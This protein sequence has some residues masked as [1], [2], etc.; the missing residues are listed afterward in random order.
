MATATAVVPVVTA[1]SLVPTATGAA[2]TGGAGSLPATPACREPALATLAQTEGPYFKVGA[3]GRNS[4]M[5]AGLAGTPLLLR[6]LVLSTRCRPVGQ[7]RLDFW[8]ADARGQYDNSGFT[9]RGYQLT[10]E[11]GHYWLET[12]MPGLYPGRTRHIHVKLQTPG[13]P[14]L[15]TQLYFPGEVQNARDSIFDARLVV[16]MQEVAGGRSATFDFVLDLG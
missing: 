11:A 8:Q 5:T 4:L 15:T 9:L 3:P 6:G 2:T 13:R 16:A 14:A 10:D 12:I 1:T 7:V